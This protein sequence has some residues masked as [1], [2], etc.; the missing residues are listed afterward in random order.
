MNEKWKQN[1]WVVENAEG[2]RTIAD[3]LEESD[4]KRI[5]EAVNSCSTLTEALRAVIDDGKCSDSVMQQCRSA[6]KVNG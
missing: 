1:G 6:L 5:V 4:A 2:D 3:C